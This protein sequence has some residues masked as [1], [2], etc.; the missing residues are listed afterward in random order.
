MDRESWALH[1][2][3]NIYYYTVYQARGG[4]GLFSVS[5]VQ[6][7]RTKTTFMSDNPSCQIVLPMQRY[8]S[9]HKT[10]VEGKSQNGHK[11]GMWPHRN[12][13]IKPIYGVRYNYSDQVI[14]WRF[15]SFTHAVL[16][17]FFFS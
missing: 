16:H 11:K 2:S 1:G 4:D 12:A 14:F 7:S 10:T 8:K 5:I 3:R 13:F 17:S 15:T 6:R 9:M